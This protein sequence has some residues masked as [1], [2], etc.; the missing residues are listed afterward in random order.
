MQ[1]KISSEQARAI[2]SCPRY[3]RAIK[4]AFDTGTIQKYLQ[5]PKMR[6]L[7]GALL[8]GGIGGAGGYL[9]GGTGR[10]AL[11][12]ALLGGGAGAAGGHF[13][14]GQEEAPYY[15]DPADQLPRPTTGTPEHIK[16][17][18]NLPAAEFGPQNRMIV[19]ANRG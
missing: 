7:L 18:Q 11:L 5:N 13:L 12:G 8:G 15:A 4:R 16:T 3:A 17:I 19:P 1:S 2:A 9:A 10:S 6:V 14:G